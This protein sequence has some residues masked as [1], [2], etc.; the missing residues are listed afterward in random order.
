MTC[1]IDPIDH[2][3]VG[4][5][6]L[7]DQYQQSQNLLDYVATNLIQLDIL[8]TTFQDILCSRSLDGSNYTLDIIGKLVGQ[9]REIV[10]AGTTIWFGFQGN[11]LA[12]SMG[13]L[14]NPAIGAPFI[15]VNQSPTTTRFLTDPE[16]VTFILA[17]TYRNSTD[18]TINAIL[19]HLAIIFNTT[20]Q[21]TNTPN[22]LGYSI[23][24]GRAL[25]LN[26]Q[27]LITSTN[28]LPEPAGTEVSYSDTNGPIN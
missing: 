22:I 19:S 1:G 20:I 10:T 4:Q 15:S 14:G 9:P 27:L 28:V 6:R 5:D 12:G 18:C 7:A 11:P 23:E 2:S 17:R 8:E 21:Y 26:E 24:F 13:T 16:Y 3:A 25:T